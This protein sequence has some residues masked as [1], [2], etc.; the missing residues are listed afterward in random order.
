MSLRLD[1]L[2][3]PDAVVHRLPYF[4]T[5]VGLLGFKHALDWAVATQHFHRD[6]QPFHYFV[7]PAQTVGV[8]MLPEQDRDF[9]GTLL[10]M[11]LP[12]ILIGVL[13]TVQR[14]RA[15]RLPV[16]C[17]SSVTGRCDL[18][19]PERRLAFGDRR[20]GG[21]AR[22]SALLHPSPEELRR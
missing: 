14:L 22:Q 6:W 18:A 16:S 8:L 4:L 11:A 10:V 17:F 9:F 7:L 19:A 12:F 3:R 5:G 1:S 20:S 13:L 21:S 15:V 2:W